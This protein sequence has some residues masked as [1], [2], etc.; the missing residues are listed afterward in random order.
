[1]QAHIETE[2]GMRH[3]AVR[4]AERAHDTERRGT[5]RKAGVRHGRPDASPRLEVLA[6]ALRL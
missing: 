1:V 6:L 5:P 4:D 3:G 2:A